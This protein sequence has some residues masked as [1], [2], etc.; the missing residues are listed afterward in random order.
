M[1]TNQCI[2]PFYLILYNI[3]FIQMQI[4]SFLF[5]TSIVNNNKSA[6][7]F[8]IENK[9]E[10]NEI[11]LKFTFQ[12]TKYSG[13]LKRAHANNKTAKCWSIDNIQWKNLKF[14]NELVII[15]VF[16]FSRVTEIGNLR[17]RHNKIEDFFSLNK[18]QFK[19]LK[20]HT[21]FLLNRNISLH[22]LLL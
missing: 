16:W 2:K 14:Q 12:C 20:N 4:V 1:L 6:L 21:H 7:W 3:K 22:Q 8:P 19:S 11:N 9:Q 5:W 15:F 18:I 10:L 13:W 17:I